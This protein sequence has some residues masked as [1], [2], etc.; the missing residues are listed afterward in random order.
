MLVGGADAD[1]LAG[2]PGENL[3]R[4]G[5][6]AEFG[7]TIMGFVGSDEWMEVSAAGA[8]GDLTEG[9]MLYLHPGRFAANDLGQSDA[10]AGTGQFVWED[11]EDRLWWDADGAGGAAST[12]IA[13]MPGAV[14]V[15]SWVILIGASVASCQGGAVPLA[16]AL[17]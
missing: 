14:E 9:M 15:G 4:Y 13:R 8:G 1:I 11:D 12:L 5:H 10:P 7:D 3:Y 2:G 17:G 6:A 16:A